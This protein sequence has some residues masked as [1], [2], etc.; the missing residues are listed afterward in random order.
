M[1]HMLSHV[2]GFHLI[3]NLNYNWNK[4]HGKK[5]NK[6]NVLKDRREIADETADNSNNFFSFQQT[7]N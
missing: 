2:P 4:L 6:T 3:I 5:Y 1:T 7:P